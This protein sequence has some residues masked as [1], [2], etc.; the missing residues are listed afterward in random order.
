MDFDLSRSNSN[1]GWGWNFSG[2]V[3][4]FV[5]FHLR[6]ENFCPLIQTQG[7]TFRSFIGCRWQT[8][9]II[10]GLQT[11]WNPQCLFRSSGEIKTKKKKAP[12]HQIQVHRWGNEKTEQ[13]NTHQP[14]WNWQISFSKQRIEGGTLLHSRRTSFDSVYINLPGSKENR[15]DRVQGKERPSQSGRP[16]ETD[17]YIQQAAFV[18]RSPSDAAPPPP[19]SWDVTL[20]H[21]AARKNNFVRRRR[22][23][24]RKL[25][26]CL[27]KLNE[28]ILFDLFPLSGQ[29][30]SGQQNQQH[31]FG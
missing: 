6:G 13:V 17:P 27:S 31:S 22:K 19:T 26:Y 11:V 24:P 30:E 5:L 28:V 23:W 8:T 9:S 1:K 29:T 16:A 18:L 20:I 3:W 25:F 21:T 15:S 10:R 12:W 7:A 4:L 14:T 2:P